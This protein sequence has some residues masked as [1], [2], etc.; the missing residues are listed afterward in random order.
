MYYNIRI[1]F[2]SF[3]ITSFLVKCCFLIALLLPGTN[4]LYAQEKIIPELKGVVKDDAGET[5]SGA[6][7]LIVGTKIFATSDKDGAFVL[8]NVKETASLRVSFVGFIS[9][10]LKLKSGDNNVILILI[11]S[12]NVLGEVIINTGLNI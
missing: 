9:N 6:T 3:S 5:L 8:K 7:V 12:A 2:R 4:A 1:K 11:P 10:T